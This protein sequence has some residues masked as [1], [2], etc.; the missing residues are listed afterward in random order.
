MLIKH[1]ILEQ[2]AQGNIS[3]V[4]RRWQRP[5]VRAGGQLRTAVGVLAIGCCPGGKKCSNV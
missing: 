3:L 2:I 1:Q 4:F 5:P